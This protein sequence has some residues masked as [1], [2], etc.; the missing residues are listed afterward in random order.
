MTSILTGKTRTYEFEMTREQIN[1]YTS[2]KRPL[3]QEIF[4]ELNVVDREF[5]ATGITEEE[6]AAAFPPEE[7]GEEDDE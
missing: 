1:A 4:P 3:I 2:P 7:E 5:L 6:W